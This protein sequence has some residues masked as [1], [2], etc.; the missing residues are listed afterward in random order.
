MANISGYGCD[1]NAILNRQRAI[2][3][4][5][6]PQNTVGAWGGGEIKIDRDVLVGPAVKRESLTQTRAR[7]EHQ[8]NI[9]DQ[10]VCDDGSAAIQLVW[11]CHQ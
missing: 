9:T 4:T 11:G 8:S 7:I 3:L 5:T 2:S 1:R 10:T 6:G